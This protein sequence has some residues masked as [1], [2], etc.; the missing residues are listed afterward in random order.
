M[1]GIDLSSS[2]DYIL[3]QTGR[4]KLHYIGMSQ[5]T[6]VFFVLGSLRPEYSEKIASSHMLAPVVFT[7]ANMNDLMDVVA[8]IAADVLVNIQS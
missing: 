4:Q 8:P 2:I 3:S 5:G 6:T 1:G 7:T